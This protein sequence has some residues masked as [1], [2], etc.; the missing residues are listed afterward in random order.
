MIHLATLTG[1]ARA[2]A[3]D[4]TR[5]VADRKRNYSHAAAARAGDDP[6]VLQVVGRVRS[7][8]YAAGA[9]VRQAAESVQRACDAQSAEDSELA[10]RAAVAAEIEVAQAQTVVARL[11]LD[12]VAAIFDALGASATAK[13]KGLD[14]YWR[15]ART[16]ASHNPLIYKERVVGDFA[17]NGTRPPFGWQT[18]Q[19]NT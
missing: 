14:R 10:D 12:A 9:V 17:V 15:N 7:Q 3:A 2:A 19:T 18:G 8:A 1:I 4:V 11:T 13:S 6:Q 5:A 16:I